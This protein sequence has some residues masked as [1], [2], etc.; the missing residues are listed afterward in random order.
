MF[1]NGKNDFDIW[2]DAI[3]KM[4]LTEAVAPLVRGRVLLKESEVEMYNK[5]QKLLNSKGM[6]SCHRF[7]YSLDPSELT[8]SE[9]AK[10]NNLYK[11]GQGRGVIGVDKEDNEETEDAEKTDECDLVAAPVAEVPTLPVAAPAIP[12][13]QSAFT[14]LYSAMRDGTVKT[15][16]AFSNCVDTRSAKADVLSKLERA[17]YQNISILAIEAG[18]PD[19]QGC[20]NTYCAQPAV[21]PEIPDY[22]FED[23][24]E[25]KT[26][27]HETP[28]HHFKHNLNDAINVMKVD[29]VEDRKTVANALDPVGINA[30]SAMLKANDVA[31]TSMIADE[32]DEDEETEVAEADDK[33]EE[34]DDAADKKDDAKADDKKEE[35]VEEP[36]E[37]L[38]DDK[39]SEDTK[40]EEKEEK[41][42]EESAEEPEKKDDDKEDS[43]LSASEK[44]S[45][46]DSYKKAFKAAML[47]LKFE[48][49][50][51]ELS[52]EDKVKFFTELTKAWGDKADPA[53]FM[54]D[55]EVN[56]LE[57][58][59][60][61]K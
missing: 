24:K 56:Q 49:S 16:E 13:K 8:E 58:I 36:D 5:I 21:A 52:L 45:L 46:K 33:E 7:L 51:S 31:A 48:T 35:A 60:V 53:E 34:K 3:N 30:S 28:N 59:V 11:L 61:K 9:C 41:K 1:K 22:A 54:T 26:D 15:G 14:I 32:E 29:K 40:K 4:D 12:M 47:K 20:D 50:F 39:K 18:D 38:K 42:D 55:K 19:M 44:E 23:E 10:V 27:E 25:E 37:K 6:E 57:K 2:Q 17:G 43:K